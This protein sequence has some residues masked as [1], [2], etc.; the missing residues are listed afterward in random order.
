MV[1][2]LLDQFPSELQ[3]CPDVIDSKVIL[4][5][6]FLKGHP[7]GQASYDQRYRHPRSPNHRL[8][9]ADPRINDNSFIHMILR[10]TLSISCG[11]VNHVIAESTVNQ[12]RAIPG[13]QR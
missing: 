3:R 6:N 1:L 5:L 13:C 12:A 11:F 9:V 4:S 8:P 2:L 10:P 7:A